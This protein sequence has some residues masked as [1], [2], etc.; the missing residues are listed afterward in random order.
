MKG[1]LAEASR[2]AVVLL[3]ERVHPFVIPSEVE[4][5]RGA[6]IDAARTKAGSFDFALLRSG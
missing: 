3:R 6:A 1:P 4:G 5:P 2:K